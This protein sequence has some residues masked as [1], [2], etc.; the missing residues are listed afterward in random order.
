MSCFDKIAMSCTIYIYI[1]SCN[2]ATHA[3]QNLS[4]KASYKTLFFFIVKLKK[5]K[6]NEASG[7]RNCKK[8]FSP[9]AHKKGGMIPIWKK[10]QSTINAQFTKKWWRE[11]RGY[12]GT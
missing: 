8:Y 11:L 7:W 3:T 2:F 12:R 9:F 4:C 10:N 6:V 1:V 5:N